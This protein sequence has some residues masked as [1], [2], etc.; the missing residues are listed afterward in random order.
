L[1]NIATLTSLC[2]CPALLS[3]ASGSL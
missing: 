1:F 3:M 2:V